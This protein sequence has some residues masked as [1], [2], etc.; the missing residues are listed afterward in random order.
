MF[1]MNKLYEHYIFRK[2]KVLEHSPEF[3]VAKITGQ[4][5]KPFWET[6]GIKS[7]ILIERVSGRRIVIDTKWKILKEVK[8]SDDDLKQMFIYNLHY[9]SDLSI[10]LYPKTIFDNAEKKPYRKDSFQN[11]HCKIAFAD[12][13]SDDEKLN[14]GLGERL[15]QELLINEE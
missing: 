13:F 11:L 10:L 1:D 4:T 5:R 2:L 15:Y 8:P 3:S 6:R 9:D 14:K 12:L 7:D